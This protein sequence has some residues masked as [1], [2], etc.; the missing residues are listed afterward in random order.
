MSDGLPAD[1]WDIVGAAPVLKRQQSCA[2]SRLRTAAPLQT[3]YEQFI[4]ALHAPMSNQ[5]SAEGC[6]ERYVDSE[7]LRSTVRQV[8]PPLPCSSFA[9]GGTQK[10]VA[11]FGFVGGSQP[12]GC[13]R[14][15]GDSGTGNQR[16]LEGRP[17]ALFCQAGRGGVGMLNQLLLATRFWMGQTPSVAQ[18]EPGV[19]LTIAVST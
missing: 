10:G 9:R 2:L 8:I 12:A 16:L 6:P 17:P 4:R 3:S 19:C 14:A 18:R 7:C 13:G 15:L 11:E 5:L 1:F